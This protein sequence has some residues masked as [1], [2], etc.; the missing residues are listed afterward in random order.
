[1]SLPNPWDYQINTEKYG[2]IYH[3]GGHNVS[4]LAYIGQAQVALVESVQYIPFRKTDR[5]I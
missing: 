4:K 1:M 2:G 3:E 5:A